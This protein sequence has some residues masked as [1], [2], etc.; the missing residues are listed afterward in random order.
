MPVHLPIYYTA[1][2]PRILRTFANTTLHTGVTQEIME[3]IAPHITM[4][5]ID[6]V[7]AINVSALDRIIDSRDTNREA[8]ADTEKTHAIV[9][10]AHAY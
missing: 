3:N 9:M 5:S 10:T 1:N 6:I 2:S 4:T 7:K 8:Y